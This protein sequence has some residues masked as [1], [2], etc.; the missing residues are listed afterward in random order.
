VGSRAVS[1]DHQL[2]HFWART[3]RYFELGYDRLAAA[4]TVAGLTGVAGSSALDVGTGHGMLAAALAKR[5]LNVTSGDLSVEHHTVAVNLATELG[6]GHRIRF[7][8]FDGAHLPFAEDRFASVA[9]MDVLHHLDHA[10]AMLAELSRV[11]EP[12]GT[13][14][15]ADFSE[16]GFELVSRIHRE[17]GGEHPRSAVTMNAA[18]A[19][20]ACLG[21]QL[22]NRLDRH[23]QDIACFTRGCGTV[24]S[25]RSRLG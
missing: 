15:I 2:Q 9:M 21:W 6:V 24:R 11:V 18:C 22:R 4:D 10:E 17:G 16:A 14:V 8:L 1:R 5:G 3:R 20:M 12:E 7:L 19:T 13:I 23:L 25:A